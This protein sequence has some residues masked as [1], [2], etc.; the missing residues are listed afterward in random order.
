[1]GMQAR[2]SHAAPSVV[3]YYLYS[4]KY[5]Y[6][7]YYLYYLLPHDQCANRKSSCDISHTSSLLRNDVELVYEIAAASER[8]Y[9]VGGRAP[10]G[11]ARDEQL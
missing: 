11:A 1:M 2:R 5:L 4:L 7:L 9:V 6:F 8:A 3:L 10:L